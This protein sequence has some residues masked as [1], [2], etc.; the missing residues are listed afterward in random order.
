ML[1]GFYAAGKNARV[2]GEGE[3]IERRSRPV[4]TGGLKYSLL[5]NYNPVRLSDLTKAFYGEN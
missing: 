4:K 1:R 2:P 5:P 3:M